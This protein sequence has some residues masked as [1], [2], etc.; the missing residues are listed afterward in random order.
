MGDDCVGDVDGV[1]GVDEGM[2]DVEEG[3]GNGW[4]WELWA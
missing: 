4:A 3:V 1:G 2:G